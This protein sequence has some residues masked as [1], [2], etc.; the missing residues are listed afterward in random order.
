MTNWSQGALL[1]TGNAMDLA[2]QGEGFFTIDTFRG[3]RYTRQGNFALDG[4]GRLVT[5]AGDPVLDAS[6]AHI[7]VDDKRF[8]VR[9]DGVYFLDGVE[10]GRLAVV[11]PR[12]Q[13]MLI[14]EGESLFAP[15]P[16]ARF[17]ASGAAVSQGYQER[18]NVNPVMEMSAMLQALRAYEAN[19]RAVTAQDETLDTLISQV[20]RFG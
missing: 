3:R 13:G 11:N 12:G 8:E 10:T 5:Q 6:G 9:P 18:S 17:R 16:G 15:A 2:L 1:Q 7:L 19:Q 20:G 4:R 14:K